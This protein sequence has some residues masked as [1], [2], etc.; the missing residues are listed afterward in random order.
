MPQ[1][2]IRFMQLNNTPWDKFV[3]TNSI[4]IAFMRKCSFNYGTGSSTLK[5]EVYL[6][7][8]SEYFLRDEEN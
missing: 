7:K 1:F 2:K 5:G 4:Y 6:N 3:K 8:T